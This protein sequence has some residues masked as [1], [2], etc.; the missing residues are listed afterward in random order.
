MPSPERPAATPD[1]AGAGAA[2]LRLFRAYVALTFAF[3]WVP[4]MY[5]AFTVDKGFSPAQYLQLWSLYYA[6]MVLAEVPFGWAA[7]RWGCRRLL[8][9]GPCVLAASFMLL[10]AAHTFPA[11]A[12]AMVVIGLGHAMIS[13]ADSAWLYDHLAATG[14]RHQALHEETV[15]HRWRL[16][17][18]SALDVAGGAIAFSF[19]TSAAFRLSVVVML[20]AACLAWRLPA[21]GGA[22]ARVADASTGASTGT[23]PRAGVGRDSPHG[24]AEPVRPIALP[25]LPSWAG[26]RRALSQPG[27]VWILGWYVAVFLLLRLGF[28]LYQPTLLALGA[29]DLRLHGLLLGGLNLVA[30]LAALFVVR[31]HARLGERAT[32]GLVFLLLALSFGGLSLN[33]ALA[34]PLLCGLQQV[35]FAFL[36]PVGRTALNRRISGS[37]RATLLS[38]QSMLARLATA[39]VLA[40]GPWNAALA[41]QLPSTYLSLAL[42][43]IMAALL[44]HATHRSRVSALETTPPG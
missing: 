19:G 24:P 35:A 4:V 15:A 17:G 40:F 42:L 20:A 37:E 11:A 32:A 34:M 31:V 9:A 28:Q 10:D 43:S 16:L 26:M 22:Q 13:G 27:V 6:T 39:L 38:V 30:G 1:S 44:F 36:Q 3:A 23:A 7:D 14:R 21:P 12:V 25:A 5:T 41:E 8:L 33:D 29:S 2:S 18:V